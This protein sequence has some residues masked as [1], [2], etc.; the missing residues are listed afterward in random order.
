[1]LVNMET[2]GGEGGKEI[3][4]KNKNSPDVCILFK[5]KWTITW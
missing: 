1:M 3:K 5:V 2:P 4:I